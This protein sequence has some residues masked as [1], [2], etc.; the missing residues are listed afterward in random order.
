[1]SR[2][3]IMKKV[4]NLVNVVLGFTGLGCIIM[5]MMIEGNHLFLTAGL[6]CVV[7]AFI[8]NMV[9]MARKNNR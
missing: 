1:M 3:T 4:M 5:S 9:N 7:M 6:E 2:E 8:I